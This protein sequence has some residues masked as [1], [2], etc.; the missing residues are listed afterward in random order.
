MNG[1]DHPEI[2]T[3]VDLLRHR[4]TQQSE[5]TA[6][7]FLVDG[8]TLEVSL[9][10]Q[11]LDRQSKAIAAHLQSICQ[12][13]ER[14]LLLYQPGLD[15]ISA[16][17]GCLYAGV[18]AV[19]AYPPRP[20]R[21]L[22]RIEAILADA[23]ATVALTC[24]PILSLMRR[25]FD[26]VPQL[27]TLHWIA[28][29]TLAE[30]LA[31]DWQEP[32]LTRETIAFLQYTSGST[33]APKGVMITHGN[34]LHNLSAIHHCFAHSPQSQGVIWL[35][36]YHDMGLIGGVLQ[37]LYGG[38]PVVL[39]SPLM[40]L[41]RPLRWLEAISRYRATTSGGPNFAYDLC[42]RKIPQGQREH[43]D[44]SSWELA[45]N[46]AE[47]IYYEVI[48]RFTEAFAPKGFRREAFY[49]C[50]GL[51]EAT[52]IVSGGEKT[53][54]PV[55]KSVQAKALEQNQVIYDFVTPDNR[56]T[57][58][59]CGQSLSD[60]K[61]VIV[62]PQTLEVCGDNQ[63]GEIWV[64][65][66][67]IAQ[68]YWGK[69]E[70][71]QQIFKA[72]L[73]GSPDGPFL[74]TGDLGFLAN[75]E[76]FVTGRLKDV[77]IINGRNYYPQDIERTVEQSHPLIRPN[78]SASFSVEVDGEERLVILA[79]VE[80]HYREGHGVQTHSGNGTAQSSKVKAV[81]QSIRRAVSQHH[82]LQVYDT[83]LLKVGGIPKTSSGKIQRHICR[84][85][86]LD[87]T[88]NRIED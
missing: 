78:C 82:D 27:Q 71:T 40:F 15:Y 61:I 32:V 20:N 18:V 7:R 69:V 38:F 41:Q 1:S 4:A 26:Q 45:F 68:G 33:A 59:G 76:L 48:E 14:A 79:E 86:F 72:D 6:Y 81:I 57:V 70:E 11:A 84:S 55:F 49:P 60:Q 67:S 23:E 2:N 42:V 3:L 19:P 46:G 22:E 47:P 44:L 62:D 66:P 21:S 9:T 5:Q 37:P 88:L 25:Q 85:R 51:A 58:V 74:R 63:V 77:I 28:T 80:R 54:Q 16:F 65:G 34:L 56:R 10:Y 75:G 8:E 31:M 87:Q 64:L 13:G 39:M 43:L 73:A 17:F 35:P 30:T 29:D 52:L 36:P 50:Y 83:V 12:P 24:Q 53:A